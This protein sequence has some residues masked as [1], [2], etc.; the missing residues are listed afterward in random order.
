MDLE[1][2]SLLVTLKVYQYAIEVL[3]RKKEPMVY[4]D[5]NP[6]NHCNDHHDNVSTSMQ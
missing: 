4:P 3:K 2:S 1:F 5:I 6:K